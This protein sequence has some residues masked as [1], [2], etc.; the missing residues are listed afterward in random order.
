MNRQDAELSIRRILVALDTSHHSLAALEAAAELAAALQAELE[1]L[2][3]EDVDLLRLAGLPLTREVQ[4]PAAA[5]G[6]LDPARMERQ[7][8]AQATQAHRALAAA[9]QPRKVTWSFRVVRGEVSPQVLEAATSAD[10]LSLGKASRPIARR[11]RLGSTARAAAAR[12][13]GPV[14]LV[15]RGTRV[16][17][18]VL[19]IYDG[20]PA[21]RRALAMAV[22]LGRKAGGYLTTLIVGDT[23]AR[24]SQ[25][26]VQLSRSLRNSPLFLRYR[27]ALAEEVTA[28]ML[29]HAVQSERSGTLV[30]SDTLLSSEDVV[31]LLDEVEC[32]ALL[33]R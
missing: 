19:L 7:L 12:A 20:S 15:Q 3:V 2:F 23:R 1:G 27:G 32:P 14:L 31:A 13:P 11:T 6:S 24:V 29:A 5:A 17:P 30:L 9:C 18:P 10:L 21:A 33:M 4:Y 28:A 25:M 22:R 16:K 26:R 8:R